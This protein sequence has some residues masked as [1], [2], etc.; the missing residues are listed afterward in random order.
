MQDPIRFLHLTDLHISDPSRPD[1]ELSSDTLAT[2]D[3]VIEQIAGMDPAPAFVAISGDLTNHGDAESY[4]IA[5]ERLA[6]IDMPVRV[7]LGNH[8]RRETFRPAFLGDDGDAP[9]VYDEVVAGVHLIGLDSLVPG[10]IAGRLDAEQFAFLDAALNRH[11]E[12]PKIVVIHHP[13]A[14]E[15][16]AEITWHCLDWEDS[17]RLGAMIEGRAQGLLCGHVHVPRVT[18]WHG[19]PVVVGNGLH[20]TIDPLVLDGMRV[21]EQVGYTL[22]T[23]RPSGLTAEF[24]TLPHAGRQLGHIPYEVM[25]S[26]E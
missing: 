5:A 14:L 13:P 15:P 6:R 11:P 16:G 20:N 1:E 7:T 21:M 22:C 4:R 25:R 12:L 26:F 8:D 18:F 9:H 19:V 24:V 17:T 23:L 2:L 10:R 3:A